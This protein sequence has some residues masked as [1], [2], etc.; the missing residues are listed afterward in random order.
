MNRTRFEGDTGRK[1]HWLPALCLVT[2][3]ASLFSGCGGAG[4]TMTGTGPSPPP[5][6]AFTG[7]ME[8]GSNAV[9]GAAIS[10]Y[11]AGSSGPGVGAANLLGT[12]MVTTD[13]AGKFSIPTFQCGSS[14]AQ[15]YLVGRGGS[16][17]P[18]SGGDN[19]ALVTMAALGDCGS[20]SSSTIVAMNEVTTAAAAWALAQFMGTDA[21]IGAS[22]T[23]ATGLRNAF[24]TAANLADTSKGTAPGPG[25]PANTKLETAKLNTLAA[26]LWTCNQPVSSTACAKLFSAVTV[27]SGAP[28]NTVADTLDAALSVVRNPGAN[29]AA[30][31]ANAAQSPFTPVLG[32]APHDWTLSATFG[33]CSPGCGGLNFPGSLAIDSA[34]SVWVANYF[35]GAASKFSN[36]GAPASGGGYA[37]ASLQESFGIAVDGQDSAWITNQNGNSTGSVTHLSSAGADLSGAGYSGG[38]IYY[39]V[40]VAATSGGEIW[41][42]DYANAAATLLAG[43]GTAI[44][45]PSGYAPGALPF[46]T[47]VAIDGNQNGWFAYQGGVAMVTQTGVVSSYSCCDVPAGIALDASGNVWVADYE[48]SKVLKLGPGGSVIGETAAGGVHTP[49][50]IAVDGG[51]NI[52]TANYRANTVSELNGATLQAVSPAAGYGLDASL[53]G[54]FGL[55]VDASGNVWISNAYGNTLTELI[56]AAGPVKTPSAGLPAQP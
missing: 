27:A 56:G 7:V 38:G 44:S 9:S 8:S 6:P 46:T 41:V 25:L 29:P 51:G 2:G 50:N 53:F 45:G 11:A 15:V 5:T 13:A 36:T 21:A 10:F 43:D 33:N 34:G 24:L 30:V 37:A 26:A 23:N 32:N 20:V 48:A 35:G 18:A 3:A 17:S 31:F 16:T 42:A 55:G 52:W 49:M 12:Q 22:A 40:G 14:E 4:N 54:P 47:A 39:P 28:G 1:Q 19:Q